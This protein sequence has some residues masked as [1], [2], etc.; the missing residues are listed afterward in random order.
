M[1]LNDF[2]EFGSIET[3]KNIEKLNKFDRNNSNQFDSVRLTSK[4]LEFHCILVGEHEKIMKKNI[5]LNQIVPKIEK[6]SFAKISE[7]FCIKLD[8]NL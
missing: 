4:V 8:Q 3:G 7:K 1:H 2:Y 6:I 5:L